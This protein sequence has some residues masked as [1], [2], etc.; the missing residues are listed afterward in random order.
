MR[1][2]FSPDSKLLMTNSSDGRIQVWNLAHRWPLPKRLTIEASGIHENPHAIGFLSNHTVFV[3]TIS[4]LPNT[5]KVLNLLQWDTTRNRS[6]SNLPVETA[7][8]Q[9][10]VALDAQVAVTHAQGTNV[11]SIWDLQT[12]RELQKIRPQNTVR[13]FDISS[14]GQTLGLLSG[15]RARPQVA[16]WDVASG[17]KTTLVTSPSIHSLYFSTHDKYAVVCDDQTV[18]LWNRETH[19]EDVRL[20][21]PFPP[22]TPHLSSA[23]T[24]DEEH[25]VYSSE[26][27]DLRTCQLDTLKM[28]RWEDSQIPP[29]SQALAISADGTTVAV[30]R[31]TSARGIAL[32]DLTTGEMTRVIGKW[33]IKR[34]IASFCLSFFAW[35]YCWSR[36][37][38]RRDTTVNHSARAPWAAIRT[39]RRS[40]T[41]I[42]GTLLMVT[43]IATIFAPEASSRSPATLGT[44]AVVLGLGTLLTAWG[45]H[46]LQEDP[47]QT[48]EQS[49]RHQR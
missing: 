20:T 28:V 30:A 8:W 3:V 16:L 11:L 24:L 27:G 32:Y 6:L 7:A 17:R 34:S 10:A 12:G 23:F 47:T 1:L 4:T 37:V 25:F 46:R 44:V 45:F 41:L 33:N 15:P 43:A 29:R 19:E 2:A 22:E 18:M 36:T 48:N 39:L 49:T 35:C 21:L 14:D 40:P 9:C 38:R 26:K 42:V 13:N 5:G 31:G